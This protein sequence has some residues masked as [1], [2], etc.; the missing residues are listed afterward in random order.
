MRYPHVLLMYAEAV[1]NGGQAGSM[2]AAAAV[3]EVRRRANMTELGG[4]NMDIIKH[5]RVLEFALEG[6]RFHDLLRWGELNERFKQLEREDPNFKKLISDNDYQ[7]FTPGKHE[8]LPIP[9]D[10]IESN[11]YAV[12]N[13]G[14]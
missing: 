8:W 4:V 9:I 2:S 7:G 1:V 12:Q 11:P 3:N 6:H 14:Y 5:E 10:E 13:P